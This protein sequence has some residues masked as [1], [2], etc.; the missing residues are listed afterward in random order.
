MADITTDIGKVRYNIGDIVEPYTLSDMVI[1]TFLD[2]YQD[3]YDQYR[4][5]A[6]TVDSLLALKGILAKR[7][8]RRREREGGVEV[9]VYANFTYDAIKDLL[10]Y[11]KDNPPKT[12]NYGYD[13]HMFGGVS[14][15]E[16]QRVEDDPDS[17]R[18]YP[19]VGE[20]YEDF[21]QFGNYVPWRW[22]ELP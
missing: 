19:G 14:K 13:L 18:P 16:R 2:K 10:D 21:D 11:Y 17:S 1:Q 12:A 5:W 8:E 20:T 9:E 3:E 7:S 22:R 6:A 4:V 15:K